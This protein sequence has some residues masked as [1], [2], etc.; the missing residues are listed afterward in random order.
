VRKDGIMGLLGLASHD[1]CKAHK[2]AGELQEWRGV[3]GS[4]TNR[5]KRWLC[6]ASIAISVGGE[7]D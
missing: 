4:W 5:S 2:A 1:L 3:Y 6:T 7:N